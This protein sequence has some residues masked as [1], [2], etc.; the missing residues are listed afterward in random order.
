[1][2]ENKP[3]AFSDCAAPGDCECL[4]RG[5]QHERETCAVP[6]VTAAMQ[7][8]GMLVINNDG[9]EL[10][11]TNY[12]GLEHAAKG[13]FFVSINAGCV[14]LLMPPAHENALPDMIAARSVVLTRGAYDGKEAVE[15]LFDDDTDD[16]FAIFLDISQFDRIWPPDED[17]MTIDFAIYVKGGMVWSHKCHLRR[18]AT[19]P[20]LTPWPEA[21]DTSDIPEASEAWFQ[22]AK[23]Q[24]P[25]PKTTGSRQAYLI[26]STARTVEPVTFETL[27]DMHTLIGGD[28]EVAC[29]WPN[30]DVLYVDEEGLLKP[31]RHFFSIPE[32]RDQLL[33]GNG[34][35]VGRE[36]EGEQFPAG[37][38]T[39]PPTMSLADLTRRVTFLGRR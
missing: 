14:R 18:T 4:K 23:R 37:Y 32:R 27:A 21:I 7:A 24:E 16:P 20:L 19:L 35:L 22:K 1:M 11:A 38:T 28:I 2:T 36:E 8:L 5:Y 12:W 34:L 30:G 13:L 17:G 33:V 6:N 31:D 25:T 29:Q 26:D 10:L 9:P 15:I 39:H 3:T